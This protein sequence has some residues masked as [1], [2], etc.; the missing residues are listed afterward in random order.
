MAVRPVRQRQIQRRCRQLDLLNSGRTSSNTHL[1]VCIGHTFFAISTG[2][3]FGTAA[4]LSSD[5]QV[6]PLSCLL[7]ASFMVL[8]R[9]IV[10][11]STGRA[12]AAWIS[13]VIANTLATYVLGSAA[14]MSMLPGSADAPASE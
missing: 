7:Y 1:S 8:L 4:Y 12:P 6:A 3:A 5:L 10:V 13:G 9:A 11:P 14:E 2:L